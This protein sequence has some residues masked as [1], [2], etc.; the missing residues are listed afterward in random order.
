MRHSSLSS[1][2]SSSIGALSLMAALSASPAFAQDAPPP[3]AP[4]APTVGEGDATSAD[5]SAKTETSTAV[6]DAAKAQAEAAKKAEEAK[7]AEAEAEA[8]AN[9]AAEAKAEA[10]K[11]EAA[12][13]TAEEKAEEKAADAADAKEEAKEKKDEAKEPVNCDEVCK[14]EEPA[15]SGPKQGFNYT[16]SLGVTGSLLHSLSVVGQPDGL[17]LQLGGVLNG[18]VLY[19]RKNHSWETK[20][21][22]QNA[23]TLTPAL[24]NT[25]IKSADRVDLSTQYTYTIPV[26]G[27]TWL[28]PYARG[29]LV[30]SAL[31]GQLVSAE[32]TTVQKTLNDGTTVMLMINEHNSAK[33]TT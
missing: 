11:A 20:L 6:D 5:G 9:A 3:G 13:E 21:N 22:I 18:G 28:G 26:E 16:L 27:L 25:P 14:K 23:W 2:L 24:P 12:A 7:K 19:L 29:Q 31:P 30:S 1:R 8:K 15:P 32:P 33:E 10:E 17:T 4:D